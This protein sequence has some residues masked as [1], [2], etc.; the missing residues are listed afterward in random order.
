M[1]FDGTRRVFVDMRRRRQRML[2]KVTGAAATYGL[3]AALQGN[4]MRRQRCVCLSGLFATNVVLRRSA[5]ARGAARR[6]MA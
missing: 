4:G 1:S 6:A 3:R 5:V 2:P